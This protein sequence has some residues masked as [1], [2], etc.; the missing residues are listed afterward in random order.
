MA[1]RNFIPPP[2]LMEAFVDD[3]ADDRRGGLVS[4]TMVVLC[5]YSVGIKYGDYNNEDHDD[6]ADD[7]VAPRSVSKGD[8]VRKVEKR[9]FAKRGCISCKHGRGY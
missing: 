2:K 7:E 6:E 8:R 3:V 1:N 5:G 4:G 9:A